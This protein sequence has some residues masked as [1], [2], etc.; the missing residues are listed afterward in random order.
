M[1]DKGITLITLIIVIILLI[2]LA[3]ITI[4]ISLGENGI[5]AKA[6]QA[7]DKWKNAEQQELVELNNIN[8]YLNSDGNIE[9]NVNNSEL[10]SKDIPEFTPI[11]KKCN[12][13]Y[14]EVMV[15][16]IEVTNS[17]S[18][19]GYAFLLNGE[20]VEYTKQKE[21]IYTDLQLGSSYDIS[22]IAM[23]KKGKVKISKVVTQETSNK[24]ELYINGDEYK[25]I[26]GGW[27]GKSIA[28]YGTANGQYIKTN[29][30]MY[31]KNTSTN[32]S[33]GSNYYPSWVTSKPINLSKYS[34]IVVEGQFITP[35][36]TR[37]LII[38][39]TNPTYYTQ[40]TYYGTAIL[41]N[42]TRMEMDITNIDIKELYIAITCQNSNYNNH[43]EITIRKVWLEK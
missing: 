1:K 3:S 34:K 16:E 37:N 8:E 36:Q 4:Y 5:I 24:L 18:I 30:Y 29:E 32:A 38:I 25:N 22:I 14:I 27:E 19:V 23:D 39:T 26:T 2:I 28:N 31:V 33:I 15:P 6:K 21:Y 35:D 13:D 20:V 43:T 9:N 42:T 40:G 12:G 41:E 17:N 10:I 11:I 7:R